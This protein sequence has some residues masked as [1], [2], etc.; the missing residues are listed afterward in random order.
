MKNTILIVAIILLIAGIALLAFPTFSNFIGSK[1]SKAQTDTFEERAA[2]IIP[3]MTYEEAVEKG[4]VSEDGIFLG[5][6][7]EGGGHDGADSYEEYESGARVL[8]GPDL[9]RLYDDV[10][11]YN[12]R[13]RNDQSTLLINEDAYAASVID[14]RSYGITD[15]IFGYLIIPEI[16]MWLP[17]Y[18]G[19]GDKNMSY[20]AAHMTYTTLPIGEER[21]NC[22]IAGHTDYIGRI[23][24]DNLRYLNIGDE[25]TFRNYWT[26]LHYQVVKTEICAPDQSQNI[27][28]GDD[29]DLLTL[30]T[31]VPNSKGDFDRYFVICERTE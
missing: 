24:F 5:G 13:V 19:A 26:S 20:G 7:N 31:C 8:F 11:A 10:V 12:A 16:D 28:I 3:D 18:L 27:Y 22:V 25:V 2:H 6:L 21:S 15:G 14:L 23:F 1:V 29:R 17:V 4:V 30:F 9:D